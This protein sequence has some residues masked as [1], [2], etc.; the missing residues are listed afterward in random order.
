MVL[1]KDQNL[2]ISQMGPG[3]PLGNLMRRYWYP[4]IPSSELTPERPKKRIRL[5]GEDLLLYVDAAGGLGDS[6]PTSN[7]TYGCVAEQCAHRGCSLYYG[8]LEDGGIR[9]PY[10]GWLYDNTGKILEQPFEPAESMLK[11]T[12]RQTAYPVQ[13]M[14]GLL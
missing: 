14:A 4:V 10:H 9:C 3:T 8:F 7:S 6:P 12:T 13:R 1:T 11:Y 2:R 5:L